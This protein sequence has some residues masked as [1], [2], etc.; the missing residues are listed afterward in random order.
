VVEAC[1]KLKLKQKNKSRLFN[2]NKNLLFTKR[3]LSIPIKREPITVG[4]AF[5]INNLDNSCKIITAIRLL[6]DKNLSASVPF[7]D[8]DTGI[9]A[10]RTT[11]KTKIV[12]IV[13]ATADCPASGVTVANSDLH[14]IVDRPAPFH[15]TAL[16]ANRSDVS[17]KH[18]GGK[19]GNRK[20]Y[21]FQISHFVFLLWFFN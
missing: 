16:G 12:I 13:S 10:R 1:G 19:N 14:D 15:R 6:D 9:L 2:K 5:F 4:S 3:K 17:K 8:A 21:Y 20:S 18:C 11:V 7:I